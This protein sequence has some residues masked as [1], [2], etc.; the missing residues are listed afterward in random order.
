MQKHQTCSTLIRDGMK[1]LMFNINDRVKLKDYSVYGDYTLH[2][3]QIGKI[4]TAEEDLSDTEFDFSLR[5]TDGRISN[6]VANNIIHI[7]QEW[8]NEKNF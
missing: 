7:D 5:W 8:D 6:A 4:C 2:K 3:N 1:K